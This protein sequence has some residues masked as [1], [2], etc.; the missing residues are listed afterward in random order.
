[1]KWLHFLNCHHIATPRI[2]AWQGQPLSHCCQHPTGR[3]QALRHE[4]LLGEMFLEP[5]LYLTL[6][7]LWSKLF[8]ACRLIW[9]ICWNLLELWATYPVMQAIEI[10]EPVRLVQLAVH[11]TVWHFSFSCAVKSINL[12][13]LSAMMHSIVH[14]S[15]Y[16]LSN[17]GRNAFSKIVIVT[18]RQRKCIEFPANFIKSWDR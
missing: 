6:H 16:A 12:N 17:A 13:L 4:T 9:F 15:K 7:N 11:V 14:C 5:L 18:K 2:V 10:D 1:M 8:L 3:G